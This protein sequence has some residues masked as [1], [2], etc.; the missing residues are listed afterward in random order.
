MAKKTREPSPVQEEMSDAGNDDNSGLAQ[1]EV[2]QPVRTS[3][4]RLSKAT[5]KLLL[6]G[7]S[8]LITDVDSSLT[9]SLEEG[10]SGSEQD[11]LPARIASGRRPKAT[12]KLQQLGVSYLLADI[13]LR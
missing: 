1:L 5:T 3:S 13:I 7:V 8:P 9:F 10:D 11:I 2:V 12:T 4:G 6:L